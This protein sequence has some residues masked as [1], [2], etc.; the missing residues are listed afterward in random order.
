MLGRHIYKVFLLTFILS[1]IYEDKK[2]IGILYMKKK[3]YQN[4]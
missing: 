2:Y 1:K 4:I 3:V